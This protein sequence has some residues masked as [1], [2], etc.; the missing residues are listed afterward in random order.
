MKEWI[1]QF[2]IDNLLPVAITAGVVALGSLVAS[3]KL[4]IRYAGNAMIQIADA[5]EDDKISKAEMKQ[6]KKDVWKIITPW[7]KTPKIINNG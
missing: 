4:T 3:I 6:I 5:L 7:R 2:L 1:I